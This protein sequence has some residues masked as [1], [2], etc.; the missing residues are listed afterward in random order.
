MHISQPAVTKH[1]KELESKLGVAL[2]AR[3]GN[4]IYLTNEGTLAL[5]HLKSIKKQYASLEYELG[6]IT[7]N[8]KGELTI[9]ASSTISQY[10]IPAVLASFH[11]RYPEIRITLLNGNSSEIEELLLK[12]K[13]DLAMVEND[14][15]RSDIRY[16]PVMD[17]KIIAITG[18]T[19]VYAGLKEISL[20]DLEQIPLL[21]RE[22][23]SGT[24]EV[25]EKSLKGKG[26]GIDHLNIFMH[27][28]A[29]ETIKNFLDNF[30]GIALVSEWAI[31]REAESKRFKTINLK[32]ILFE[33]QFRAATLLGPEFRIPWLFI[34]YFKEY[35]I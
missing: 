11:K 31:K 23:G 3:R 18:A 6:N 15:S 9:G 10:V 4:K 12:G 21:L 13:I 24:L 26:I 35:N 29:T 7:G 34:D 30:D 1:I 19:S 5:T 2:F 17:D 16:I 27:L 32:N 8:H 22:R 33:R 20:I 28:G 14:S 25:I